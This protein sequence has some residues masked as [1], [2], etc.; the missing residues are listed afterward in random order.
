MARSDI[1]TKSA[2]DIARS[3]K[4]AQLWS[5]IAALG[6]LLSGAFALGGKLIPK[7]VGDSEGLVPCSKADGYPLGDWISSGEVTSGPGTTDSRGK[8]QNTSTDPRLRFDDLKAGYWVTNE[9]LAQPSRT[10]RLENALEPGK[11]AAIIFTAK[12]S[13]GKNDYTSTFNPKVS[14]CGCYMS[15][16]FQDSVGHKGEATYFWR[17]RERYWVAKSSN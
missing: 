7:S 2:L 5:V 13:D 8:Q 12:S 1:A 15:G 9:P 16:P 3:L 10:F 14:P 4:P 6:T 11:I 17:G